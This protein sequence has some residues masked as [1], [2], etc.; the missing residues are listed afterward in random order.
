MIGQISARGRRR[1]RNSGESSIAFVIT[2]QCVSTDKT[3]CSHRAAD[4]SIAAETLFSATSIYIVYGLSAQRGCYW[5]NTRGCDVIGPATDRLSSTGI[6][7]GVIDRGRPAHRVGNRAN[8]S[9]IAP[10]ARRYCC[11]QRH[12]IIIVSACTFAV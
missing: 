12:E 5:R 8:V 11:S 1:E 7:R 4:S 6:R 10:A 2:A 9:V 3:S